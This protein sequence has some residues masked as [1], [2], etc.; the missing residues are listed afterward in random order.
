ME[1]KDNAGIHNDQL[2]PDE[3]VE[4]NETE[5]DIKKITRRK[6]VLNKI[7]EK[8][9]EQVSQSGDEKSAETGGNDQITPF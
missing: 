6:D 8:M 3:D 1:Q 5:P 9:I 2:S 7:L 4:Q